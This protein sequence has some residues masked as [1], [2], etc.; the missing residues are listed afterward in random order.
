LVLL[1]D[2]HSFFDVRDF[3]DARSSSA[4]SACGAVGVGDVDVV[5][6][7]FFGYRSQGARLIAQVDAQDFGFVVGH[8]E[9]FEDFFGVFGG[10]E[11][12]SQY[13]VLNRVHY[14]HSRY[15]DFDTGKFTED[16]GEDARFVHH[17]D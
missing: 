2:F 12:D 13:S 15:I 1:E 5:S 4:F 17:K 8:I 16:V 9:F 11:D 7:K 3:K 14:G 10:S 6:G